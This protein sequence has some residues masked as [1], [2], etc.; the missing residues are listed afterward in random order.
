MRKD[1]PRTPRHELTSS[2]LGFGGVGAELSAAKAGFL[3]SDNVMVFSG[4]LGE[5]LEMLRWTRLPEPVAT[6]LEGVAVTYGW[7][8][9]DDLDHFEV[10]TEEWMP[11]PDP[12]LLSDLLDLV[13]GADCQD[14][15]IISRDL[16]I[17]LIPPILMGSWDDRLGLPIIDQAGI[18]RL[19][20]LYRNLVRPNFPDSPGPFGLESPGSASL[21]EGAL[22]SGVLNSLPAFPDADWDVL[23]D[24]KSRLEASR[25][26]LQAAV[27]SLSRDLK[28]VPI[29]ELDRASALLIREKV[30]PAVEL[31][32]SQLDE[33][34]VLP[35]L[36]RI[37]SDGPVP[38]LVATIGLAVSSWAGQPSYQA[39]IG[40][41]V[42]QS[43]LV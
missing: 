33:L 35:S 30:Y 19:Q 42:L 28:D 29:Q 12:Q 40:A 17:S 13:K 26:N 22:A 41:L 5:A 7:D 43:H 3:Y 24:V 32:D 18:E 6:F 34:K 11:E 16:S 21:R 8:K 25:K 39:A 37:A 2:V 23:R 20:G 31:I 4:G 15:A 14:I 38:A 1:L 9:Q 10:I 27:I 36:L